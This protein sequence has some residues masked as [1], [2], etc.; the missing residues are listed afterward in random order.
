MIKLLKKINGQALVEYAL[1]SV[2]ITLAVLGVYMAAAA[3]YK[4]VLNEIIEG[5]EKAHYLEMFM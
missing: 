4:N 1:L 3:A 2:F 5:I